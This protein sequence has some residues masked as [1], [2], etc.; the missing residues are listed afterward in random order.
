MQTS[1]LMKCQ[2][3]IS[4]KADTMEDVNVLAPGNEFTSP[5]CSVNRMIIKLDNIQGHH[6]HTL[7][8]YGAGGHSVTSK[9]GKNREELNT[10]TLTILCGSVLFRGQMV[11]IT[12]IQDAQGHGVDGFITCAL[13]MI[14][15]IMS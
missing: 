12:H 8:P 13:I 9:F 4:V 14:V 1:I 7:V 10:V 5:M 2:V 15:T 3:T 11:Y 6:S